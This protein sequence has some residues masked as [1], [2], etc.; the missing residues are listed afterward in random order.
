MVGA[1]N[2]NR[3]KVQRPPYLSASDVA[4]IIADMHSMREQLN[5]QMRK[6][7]AQSKQ[8]RA[9]EMQKIRMLEAVNALVA[10]VSEPFSMVP[11]S[12]HRAVMSMGV[13]PHLGWPGRDSVAS[14]SNTAASADTAS[15]GSESSG[16]TFITEPEAL[17]K[18]LVSREGVEFNMDFDRMQEL[19]R[20]DR[21]KAG[22]GVDQEDK[23]KR[24]GSE[25]SGLVRYLRIGA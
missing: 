23:S 5:G 25:S 11:V 2:A 7:Q 18:G 3:A 19:I 13:N 8:I 9:I 14:T 1:T 24:S 15:S 4:A 16:T 20:L 10:A 21:R 17:G 12:S 22:P 6:I